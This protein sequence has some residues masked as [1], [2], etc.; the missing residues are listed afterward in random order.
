MPKAIAFYRSIRSRPASQLKP[1]SPRTSYALWVLFISASIA[2]LST[3]PFF[4]EENVFR[5]TSS[6]L[7]TPAGV[8]MT[9]LAAQ[10]PL[11]AQDEQLRAVL[12]A[13]GLDARLYYA[14]FGNNVVRDCPYAIP[15]ELD[16]DNSYLLY[17]APGLIFPHIAH[18]FALAIATSSWFVGRDGARWRTLAT[19]AGIVLGIAEFYTITTYDSTHNQRS[20][21]VNEI[22]F[23]HWKVQV[24]RGLAIAAIDGLLGWAMWLQATGRAFVV[25]ASTS[26]Q[27][28][29]QSMMLEAALAKIRGLGVLRNGTVRSA[30]MRRRADDY[31]SKDAEVTRDIFEEPAVLQ[32][33]RNALR[34]L[35][36]SKLERDADA[37]LESMFTTGQTG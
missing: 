1:I 18:L 4:A 37:F 32:A 25:P 12:D 21:R 35:D 23:V 30:D 20:T 27:L 7:Q 8:L 29:A 31:W 15:G 22:D 28:A 10:R 3:F 5:R 9:R 19:V 16:S 34:R 13:G 11:T 26:D 17:A 33:Q 24:W 6:R 2:F 14:R 36:V